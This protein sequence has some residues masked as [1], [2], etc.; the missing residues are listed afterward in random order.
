ML[1]DTN[2]KHAKPNLV[3]HPHHLASEIALPYENTNILE[4][5]ELEY[6]AL[7]QNIRIGIVKQDKEGRIIVANNAALTML[8]LTKDQMMGIT[9]IDPSWNVIHEDGSEFPGHTHPAPT[10]IRTLQP[11]HDVVMGVLRPTTNDRV[12]ILVSAEPQ[13]DSEGN[14]KYVFCTFTDISDYKKVQTELDVT[15]KVLT[16]ISNHS[17]DMF[18]IMDTIGRY[19]YVSKAATI[20]S[21]YSEEELLQVNALDL[22]PKKTKDFIQQLLLNMPVVGKIENMLGKIICKDGTVKYISWSFQWDDTAKLIYVNGR[23]KTQVVKATREAEAKRIADEQEKRH[24]IFETEAQK[25]YEISH[26]LHENVGQI[27]ATV[28]MYLDRFE[29]NGSKEVLQESKDLLS[30]CIDE[31]RAITYVNSIPKF[32]DVGFSNAIHLLMQLQLKKHDVVHALHLD[33]DEAT[34]GNSNRIN[35]YRLIQLWLGHIVNR[36]KLTSVL[37]AITA[38]GDELTLEI[39]DEVAVAIN[40]TDYLSQ[41]LMPIKERLNMIGGSMHLQPSADNKCFTITFRLKKEMD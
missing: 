5:R 20:I 27:I 35:I 34:I 39:T 33:I 18:G 19:H 38:D 15:N 8:G 37:V 17:L 25:R 28:K 16:N 24:L 3:A 14:F 21:G 23:D 22:A 2:N 36:D 4:D 30:M 1:L 29:K 10:A 11:V 41:N 13:F 26:E 31:L 7:V 6:Q 32:N 12:W 9:S 40:Y